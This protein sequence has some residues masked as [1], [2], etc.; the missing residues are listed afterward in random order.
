M[1]AREKRLLAAC[2]AVIFIAGSSVLA[3]EYMDRSKD[4]EKRITTLKGEKG[5]AEAWIQDRA[6]WAKRASWIDATLPKTDSLG[7]A[8]GELLEEIQNA[9]LDRGMKII[10][11]TPNEPTKTEHYQ[12]VSVNLQLRGDMAITMDWLSTLQSPETFQ[13]VKSLDIDPDGKAKEK[14][15]QC[16]TTLTIARWFKPEGT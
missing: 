7:R 8:Q 2:G 13:V 12:E 10:K 4:V 5:D 14:T 11:T 15:P 3:K 6:L 16:F 9:I 1:N